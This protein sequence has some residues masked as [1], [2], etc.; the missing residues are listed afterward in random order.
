MS[1]FELGDKQMIGINLKEALANPGNDHYDI[2]LR[3]GDKLVVPQYSNIVTING[4]VR[5]PNAVAYRQ[6]AKLSY[7]ID[8]AGGFGQRAQKRRVF[9]VNMNGTATRVRPA[10]DITPGCT[11]LVPSRARRSRM[12]LGEIVSIGTMTATLGTV[13]ATLLK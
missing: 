8:Q 2:V 1:Q 7:Y 12:S 11:I 4:Q 13:I 5:Y 3:D 9:A 6:G 10:K